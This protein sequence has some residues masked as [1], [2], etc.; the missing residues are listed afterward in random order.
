VASHV[1][2]ADLGD[3]REVARHD[4]LVR[5][6]GLE[7][8]VRDV[9]PNNAAQPSRLPL[10]GRPFLRRR[11]RRRATEARHDGV[12]TLQRLRTADL[13]DAVLA[14]GPGEVLEK[15]AVTAMG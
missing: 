6:D 12:S 10:L 8:D 3:H 9:A 14:E 13:E 5:P 1:I 15:V 7:A 11:G 4:G 2:E